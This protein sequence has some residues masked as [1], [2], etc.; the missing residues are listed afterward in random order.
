LRLQVIEEMKDYVPLTDFFKRPALRKRCF[1]G[2]LTMA[3]GQCTGTIVINNYGPFLYKKLGFS[4]VDQLLIQA[5]WISV[6]FFGNVFNAIVVDRVGRVRMLL[7]GLAGDVVALVG[8]CITVAR[9]EATGSP[10]DAKLAVFFLFLHIGFYGTTVDASTY[11][12][13]AEIF[14]NPLRARGIGISIS[15]L[16]MAVI[17]FTSAAP[18]AFDNVGWKYYLVF[19]ILTAICVVVIYF[20][21][22]E[23]KGVAL[24]DIADIFGDG[25]VLSDERE[26]AVHR[27][28]KESGYQ[29][30]VLD[31][32]HHQDILE[33]GHYDEKEGAAIHV[34]HNEVV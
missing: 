21:F 4:V 15:G 5:G 16:F 30:E 22:P 10:T 1:I 19:V 3:A 2:W 25:I 11:I 8:E 31:D 27:K 7:I 12:Y 29:A 32:V 18:V 33:D 20:T 34:E 26:E 17:V 14:P 28:F 9:Y 23:T 13:A 24:E 6:C